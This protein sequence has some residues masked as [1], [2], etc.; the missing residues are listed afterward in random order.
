MAGEATVAIGH[1]SART[2]VNTRSPSYFTT[3][4][5]NVPCKCFHGGRRRQG[6][7]FPEPLPAPHV[8]ARVPLT[9]MRGGHSHPYLTHRPRGHED[10]QPEQPPGTGGTAG[11]H[12]GVGST[13][14]RPQ[15]GSRPGEAG[16]PF[17]T[18]NGSRTHVRHAG[19]SGQP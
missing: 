1:T 18:T 7:R 8:R 11:P 14:P 5:S 4:D 19:L 13:P 10:R 2:R 16:L 15:G 6:W 3:R 17:P 9:A 12:P